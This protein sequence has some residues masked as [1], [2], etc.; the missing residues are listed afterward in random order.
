M[1]SW[2]KYL[3]NSKEINP[4]WTALV[5]FDNWFCV[6]FDRYWQ[7]FIYVKKTGHMSPPNIEIFT[8]FLNFL[9]GNLYRSI[10]TDQ[11]LFW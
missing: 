3:I 11:F 10:Y 4:Y 1:Q 6:N 5:T 2:I 9:R 8:I 7:R